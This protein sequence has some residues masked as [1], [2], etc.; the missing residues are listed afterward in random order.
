M[1]NIAVIPIDN[2]PVCYD[3]IYETLSINK[4]IN[5]FMPPVEFLGDLKKVSKIGKILSWLKNLNNIDIVI[6]S[7]DTIGYGGLIPSRRTCDSFVKVK[8]RIDRFLKIMKKHNAKIYAFSSIMR[9]SNNN[10]NEEEKVYWDKYGKLIFEYSTIVHKI[11]NQKNLTLI[12]KLKE[13]KKQIPKDILKDYIQTRLRNFKINKYY[14]NLQKNKIFNTLILS[15]DDCSEYGLNI[16][17]SCILNKKGKGI[18]NFFIKTGADEIPFILATKAY[19]DLFNRNKKI[20]IAI[21]YA[22]PLSINKVSK[23]ENKSVKDSISESIMI[24]GCEITNIAD[25]DCILFVNN[26]TNE[27]GELVMGIF[28]QTSK[29]IIPL[30]SIIKPFFV[31]D[32]L[33]AN[34]ADF[35]F[36][37]NNKKIFKNEKFLG[38]SAWN[39][40]S[41]SLGSA[42]ACAIIKYCSKEEDANENIFKKIQAKRLLD[43]WIYQSFVRQK[44][45]SNI[46]N[47][48]NKIL[49]K[50]M[51]KYQKQIEIMLNYNLDNIYYT[52]PWKRFFEIRIEL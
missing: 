5:I 26:F 2:R 30:N 29:Y 36:V 9:I 4:N 38:Y 37:K 45:K 47:L 7:L 35:D 11:I 52:Y 42:L 40:T 12:P 17:E 25:A 39:T 22:N 14:L 15:L 16:F 31:V 10:I 41:N 8:K 28:E 32:I 24:S 43:D 13:L 51:D 33:S 20:K 21:N 50:Y 1:I 18:D 6:C 34:G 27:Q 44:L 19:N 3:L 49:K 48:N 46:K 23:Y